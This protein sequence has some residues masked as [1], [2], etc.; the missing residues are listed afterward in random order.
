MHKFFWTVIAAALT[1]SPAFSAANPAAATALVEQALK[2]ELGVGKLPAVEKALKSLG[3]K[4]N[5]DAGEYLLTKPVR[6]FG[7]DVSRITVNNDPVELYMADL[8]GLKEADIA[9]AAGLT[10]SPAHYSRETKHGVL[11]VGKSEVVWLGC[12]VTK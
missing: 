4:F 1:S 11:E 6:V 8:P 5:A 10:G 3:A 9:K 2:C 7:L 12:S